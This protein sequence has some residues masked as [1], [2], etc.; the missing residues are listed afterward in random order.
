VVVDIDRERLITRME[1]YFDPKIDSHAMA[2]I[3][4]RAMEDGA[5]FSA[6]QTRQY[7]IK[8]GFRPDGIVRYAYRPFDIRWLYWE[9]ETKLLDEKRAEYFTSVGVGVP[10][11]LTQQRPRRHWSPCQFTQAIGCLDLMDRGASVF[12][13]RISPPGSLLKDTHDAAPNLSP[14]A[15]KFLAGVGA[16]A[17]DLFWHTIAVMHSPEYH[18]QSEGS[19]K[20]DWPRIPLPATR[21][22]LLASAALGREVAA[23]LDPECPAPRAAERLKS[24]ATVTA[25]EGRLD[26][27]AGDLEITAGWGHAG[28]A[29]VTMPAK[30]RVVVREMTAA[31]RDACPPAWLISWAP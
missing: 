2:Q 9:P 27:D 5:R 12:P 11:F 25:V 14:S 8:R 13:L 19:L 7:L 17:D 6:R 26:P 1:A 15:T 4:P 16:T 20:Q 28:K 10:C 29:G 24:I 22:T 3:A 30:G 23:L 21:E 18:Q 31:E